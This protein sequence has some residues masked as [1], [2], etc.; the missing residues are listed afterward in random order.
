MRKNWGEHGQRHHDQPDD[1]RR[2]NPPSTRARLTAGTDGDDYLHSRRRVS[3]AGPSP[4]H[5][6]RAAL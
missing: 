2:V 5:L 4:A 1:A 6:R 3:Q